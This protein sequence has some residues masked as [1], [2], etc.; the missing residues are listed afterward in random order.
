MSGRAPRKKL[1]TVLK[2]HLEHTVAVGRAALLDSRKVF[3]GFC[4]FGAQSGSLLEAAFGSK[5]EHLA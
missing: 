3:V 5:T 2:N 4:V 1:L